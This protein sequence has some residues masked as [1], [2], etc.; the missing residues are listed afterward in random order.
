MKT[1][2]N[3]ISNIISEKFEQ[4]GYDKEYG[5]A[6]VSNR[7]DLCEF[8]CNGALAAAKKYKKA[9]RA[10]ATEVVEALNSNEVF[11][12]LTIEGSGFINI[13]VE[14]GFLN[15][16][17]NYM[18]NDKKCGCVENANPKKIVVD[19]GGA[20]VAKPLHVGHLRPAIIGES[21]KRIAKF[22][23]NEVIG[24]VHLGDWG[25]QMGMVISELKRREPGLTY[26]DPNFKGEYPKESPITIDELEEIY[27]YA[28]KLA[29][30][31][32]K[33]MEE[34][35]EATVELQNGRQGYMALWKHILNIS[36]TDLK[37]NYGELNVNF[38]LW[39]GESDANKYI[40]N[41]VDYLKKNN[42]A[43]TSQGALVV[44]VAREDDKSPVPPFLVLKSDGAS[45]YGTTDLATIVQRIQDYSPD[46]IIY[47][48]D[49][50]QSMYFE[51]LFRAAKMTKIAGEDLKLQFVGFGTMN[52]KDGK[53]FKTREGGVMRLENLISIIKSV[54]KTKLDENKTIDENDVEE[55]CR[56]VGLAALK[57]ADL[58]NQPT[59]DYVFDID[60]F[61]SFEGSTGPYILYTVV[62][63]KSILAKVAKADDDKILSPYSDT[64]RKLML[65]LVK[66]SEM[67]ELSYN[68]KLP[69][70]ICEYI[71]DLSN[72]FNKFYANN[73]IV[74]E[75][76]LQKQASWIN[77]LNLTQKVLT[78]SLDLLGLETC[79]RM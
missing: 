39:K 79:E 69:N 57:Y 12:K 74:T 25:L 70:K 43:H 8:Q 50:R 33:A 59:K 66:F 73:K 77:L 52:G 54:V 2:I 28:S 36:V 6:I 10:I 75:E 48:A 53:P 65:Q 22:L 27:P 38:E 32:E 76:D 42:Y 5:K 72:A 31:D 56:K 34:A 45:L 78:T 17:I 35:K 60:R 55:V 9:P 14:N 21:I 13:N 23:G 62:R 30:S 47:L 58:S 68:N 71:Y 64:E 44:D 20:N 16:Y 61:T 1:F 67:V 46:E 40:P 37:K 4:C 3:E 26:F 18:Y 19:Y 41:M 15:K 63:I 29:K 11:E 51:Q 7:P 49:K 24:D